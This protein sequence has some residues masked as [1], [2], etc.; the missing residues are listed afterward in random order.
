MNSTM[1]RII[2]EK[3]NRNRPHKYLDFGYRDRADYAD[4]AVDTNDYRDGADYARGG[5][6]DR[7]YRDRAD[8]GRG[9]YRG[10]M[11]YRGDYGDYE[12]DEAMY[13]GRRGV[14]G[15]GPYGIGGRRYYPSRR[16]DRAM[17]DYGSDEQLRL[18]K[19]EMQEWKEQLENADGSYGEHFNPNQIK[20]AFQSMGIQPRDYTEKDLCL[21]A[22][23]LYS[24]YCDVLRV[25]IPKEKEVHAYVAMARAFLEDP[26][27]SMQGSEK[28]AAYYYAIVDDE[29]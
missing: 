10:N 9:E 4:Y 7:A 12:D 2:M 16:R 19:R 11:E 18:S 17:D 20:Q 13:D 15:T 8:Y 29:D 21:T 24:D 26:D 5:Y 22:N 27:A 14:K 1:R 25:Y 23:M 3:Q 28:L 6:R